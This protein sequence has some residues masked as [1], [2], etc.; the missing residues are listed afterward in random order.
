M[1]KSYVIAIPSYKR[2]ETLK[3]RTLALLHTYKIPSNKIYIFVATPEEK[4]LYQEHLDSNTY[5]ELVVGKPGI[6]NIR[7]F[8]PKYFREGQPIVYMDDDLYHVWECVNNVMPFDKKNNKL[9]KMKSLDAFIK[10]AFKLSK[11]SNFGNWGVYPTDNPYFMKPTAKDIN[12]Y[13][14]TKLT[15]LIGFLT[16][17]INSHKAEI[18]TIGDKEDY[19]RSI[20]YFL[21]DGGI[22]RFNNVS[23][24]TKCYKEQGGMQFDRKKERSKVNAE[25][26]MKDYPEFVKINPSR[27]SGFVEIRLRDSRKDAPK[28]L[29]NNNGT[30]KKL[31]RSTEI[32]KKKVS[33]KKNKFSKKLKS[34][35]K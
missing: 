19:E 20:K 30:T 1:D 10:K 9:I 34:C 6:Q 11:N 24:A 16:G 13:T 22:L 27:K 2:H 21:K 17:V 12:A 32:K 3:K 7:N 23:C 4:K 25:K 28:I 29:L 18:R 33:I 8:M 35:K 5:C 14:S 31:S 26:L 15:F